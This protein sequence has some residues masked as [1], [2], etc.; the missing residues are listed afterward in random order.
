MFVPFAQKIAPQ[1]SSCFG[2]MELSLAF[3]SQ[4]CL[5]SF[6]FD[7]AYKSTFLL[8]DTKIGTF[9]GAHVDANFVEGLALFNI[10]L[11]HA[12]LLFG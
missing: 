11:N 9:F 2:L 6:R 1:N 10:F 4:S 3:F 7:K 8:R 5:V 12:L